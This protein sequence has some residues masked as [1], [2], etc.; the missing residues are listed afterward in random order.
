MNQFL[1]EGSRINSILGVKAKTII[2]KYAH[3]MH[4]SVYDYDSNGNIIHI[5][6]TITYYY[7]DNEFLPNILESNRE[8]Y[9]KYDKNNKIICIDDSI[10][11][12]INYKYKN[13]GKYFIQTE[14]RY[15]YNKNEK[16]ILKVVS[17]KKYDDNDNVV[18][19][20]RFINNELLYTRSFIYEIDKNG[21]KV[22]EV[23]VRNTYNK[24]G[25]GIRDNVITYENEYDNKGN[26]VKEKFHR[27]N[28][29]SITIYEYDYDNLNIS[30]ITDDHTIAQ[31][32][33]KEV[34]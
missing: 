30:I 7:N 26:C 11:G 13:D 5:T 15:N 14:T 6:T 9:I 31:Y 16:E 12:K 19:K 33:V 23:E 2:V 20:S 17:I 21:N 27:Y 10:D 28:K 18:F 4:K 34:L 32:S 3:R 29:D 25:E 22:K 8:V 24:Y 1:I